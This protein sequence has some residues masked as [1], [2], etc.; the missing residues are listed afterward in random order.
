MA[1][2]TQNEKLSSDE[3][4]KEESNYLRGTLESSLKNDITGSLPFEDM[5]ILKF[6]GSYQQHDRDL[7]K[8]RRKQKLEPLYQFMIRVRAAGGVA[9]PA[10]WLALDKISTDFADGTLKLTTRQSFQFHGIF[11]KNLKTSIQAINASLLSTIATCGDVNRNVMCNPNPFKSAVAEEAYNYAAQLSEYFLPKSN[12][13]YEIWLDKEKVK[14]TQEE[15]EPLYKKRYLPRKF[16]IGIAIPPNNDID[17]Y[18]SDLGF[19]VI[20]E[21]GKLVG[22]NV[23]VGG[24]MGAT[25]GDESTYRRLADYIGFITPEELIPVAEKVIEIQRDF[26]N[27]VDRKHARI[28]YTIAHRGIDWFVDELQKRL[29]YT[30]APNKPFIFTTNGDLYGWLKGINNR[31]F[32]TLFVENGR[33]RDAENYTLKTALRE[34]AQV[35]TGDFRLTGN[36]NLIIGNV[37]E[38]DKAEIEAI[39]IKHGVIND[40]SHTG[41]RRNAI[42]CV[43]LNT[44]GLAFAEAE[45]YLPSLIT[46]LDVIIRKYGLDEEAITIRMTGCPNGCGRSRLGEIGFIGKSPGRYNLYLG[47]SHNG[48][49]LNTLY[50]EQLDEAQILKELEPIIKSYAEERKEGETFGDFVHRKEIVQ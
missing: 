9:T 3:L 8:E 23:S 42:A 48:D 7:E 43:A 49:R 44:C 22:F 4:L 15:V 17:I 5:K 2:S 40:T 30:L 27:R 20:E 11:K 38:E 33:V 10:Q 28:K 6:H 26:G 34:I 1:N 37:K 32:Y 36:Q 12:A 47:A 35:H 29:G 21:D 39:L 24:G 31:W 16:K 14:T 25:F 41:L 45:R 50:L 13:Y 46:K 19:T 18:A